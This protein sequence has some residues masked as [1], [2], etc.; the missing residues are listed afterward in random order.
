MFKAGDVVLG[1]FATKDGKVLNH[2]SLVLK[3]TEE[4]SILVYTTSLKGQTSA[5]RVFS[6]ADMA[7]ANW[8]K[9]CRWDASKLSLVPNLLIRKV[10]TITKA[11]LCKIQD[12]VQ[13]AAKQRTLSVAR[14]SV[15]NEVFAV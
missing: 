5:S 11:T 9:P 6:A 10:G 1:S 12:G 7:L 3:S 13:E 2:Y 4:G 15:T 14:L 8:A